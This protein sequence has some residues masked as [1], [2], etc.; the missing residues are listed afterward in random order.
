[1][2]LSLPVVLGYAPLAVLAQ[3]DAVPT[4]TV[5]ALIS[6]VLALLALNG[7]VVKWLLSQ[8]EAGRKL[9]ES[10]QDKHEA[11]LTRIATVFEGEV[12]K[13]REQERQ[14]TESERT[15]WFAALKDMRDE[16]ERDRNH[17]ARDREQWAILAD[18]ERKR[19][20]SEHQ[21]VMNKIEEIVSAVR[22]A[23]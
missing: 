1:V 18:A 22:R 9:V 15:T 23:P 10:S 7:F 8:V 4:T 5:G 12:A 6:V 20:S 3:A 2:K 17:L 19:R 16:S 21:L 11:I 14:R 13:V